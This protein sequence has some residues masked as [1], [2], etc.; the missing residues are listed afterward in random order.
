MKRIVLLVLVFVL[1]AFPMSSQI[2]NVPG[3][4]T[5]I[6]A[7]I[8]VSNDGDTVLVA[9]GTYY[10][11]INFQGK[12][13]T[14][15]SKFIND[16]DTSFISRTIIDGSQYTD[17]RNASTVTLKSGEDTT[18]VL[19]GFTVTGGADLGSTIVWDITPHIFESKYHNSLDDEDITTEEAVD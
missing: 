1:G 3:D 6:Q 18:S 16:G 8:D 19:M 17:W 13:I 2:I 14:V 4:Q 9:E 12:A 5:S 7:A 15:A 11:N 10:E